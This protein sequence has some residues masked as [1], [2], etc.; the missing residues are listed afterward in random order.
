MT[1]EHRLIGRVAKPGQVSAGKASVKAAQQSQVIAPP[2]YVP[3][4][5]NLQDKGVGAKFE[6]LTNPQMPFNDPGYQLPGA[7]NPVYSSKAEL[8]AGL[9]NGLYSQDQYNAALDRISRGASG[10]DP[11][12]FRA[13]AD[14]N[15]PTPGIPT[16]PGGQ[17]TPPGAADPTRPLFSAPGKAVQTV[18]PPSPVVKDAPKALTNEELT[19]AVEKRRKTRMMELGVTEENYQFAKDILSRGGKIGG[20]ENGQVF[21]TMPDGTRVGSP[22]NDM[23]TQ[24]MVEA[25]TT[26]Y[27]TEVVDEQQEQMDAFK[28]QQTTQMTADNQNRQEQQ[29]EGTETPTSP[30]A[31]TAIP[32]IDQT[33]QSLQAL[34]ANGGGMSQQVFSAYLPAILSRLTQAQ[35]LRSRIATM[36]TPEEIGAMVNADPNVTA[37]ESLAAR[38]ERQFDARLAEEKRILED[39]KN[40]ALE[41]NRLAAEGLELDKQIVEA[42]NKEDETRQMALNVEGEKQMRRS[43]N[44]EGIETSPVAIE[45]LQKKVT[46]AADHLATMRQTNNLTLLKFDNAR[47]QL[48]NDVK[49]I[50][51]DVDSKRASLYANYDDNIFNLDQFVSGARSSAYADL[52]ADLKT[53][54]EKEDALYQEAGDKVS[55]ASIAALQMQADEKTRAMQAEGNAWTRLIALKTTFGSNVPRSLLD[56]LKEYLPGV[57]LDEVAR[58]MTWTEAKEYMEAGQ[59]NIVSDMISTA[60]PDQPNAN[61]VIDRVARAYGKTAGERAEFK[62]RYAEMLADGMSFEEAVENLET[63]YWTSQTGKEE[64]AHNSRISVLGGVAQIEGVLQKY[65]ISG[66]SDGPLGPLSSR[67]ERFASIFNASSEAYNE[68]SAAVGML[69]SEIIKD[70]YGSAVT[71]QELAIA[72]QF[73]PDMTNKGEKFTA[74]I[75]NLK[76]YTEYLDKKYFNQA[77]G[78]PAPE[79]PSFAERGTKAASAGGYTTGDILSVFGGGEAT[80]PVSVSIPEVNGSFSTGF[81]NGTVTA[82]GSKFWKPGLDVAAAKGTPIRTPVGGKVEK[83]VYNPAWK[84]TPNNNEVGKSQNGGFGNQVVVAYDDGVK[85]QFSHLDKPAIG[86]DMI[87]KTLPADS[88]IGYVGNT[89]NTYGKTGVHADITGYHKDGRIMTA[90]EV[91]EYMLTRS[92]S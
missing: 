18:K 75:K 9:Q 68:M 83:V 77:V 44:A 21:F 59:E 15:Q 60:L 25:V 12:G 49:S 46:E 17:Q 28:E 50:L 90:Q 80:S 36:D 65:G 23:G 58:T 89:G 16:P 69:R 40:I 35:N 7:G 92:L 43:L 71:A 26:D 31:S 66:D 20:T 61:L 30:F 85:L 42:R 73:I 19:A 22:V 11:L 56:P 63:D 24:A 52:K 78:L 67:L 91:A 54:M 32:A 34:A 70:R 72:S 82:Y 6:Q 8:D 45:Y 1:R 86:T 14:P 64:A 33:I 3:D 79:A 2:R 62:Q 13:A 29:Q 47:S 5:V 84:G 87:G 55:E 88:E 53:L 37:A 41:A 10:V 48:A 76:E 74:N 27:E 4:Q 38:R 51:S 57:D 81:M 39:N